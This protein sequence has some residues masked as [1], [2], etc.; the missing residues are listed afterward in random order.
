[1]SELTSKQQ[2][3]VEEYLIDLNATKAAMRAGY[4]K[5]TARQVGA[6]NLSKPV[7]ATAIQKAMEERSERTGIDQDWVLNN[8]RSITERCMQVEP[9]TDSKGDPVFVENAEGGI[10][11]AFTFN[12]TG[13]NR[14]LEL[15]GKHLG[16][17]VERKEHTGKD[18]GPIQYENIDV[19]EARKRVAEQF[20]EY[21]GD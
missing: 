9:V 2:R 18:G 1:M 13:A 20:A 6:E 21:T 14:A 15:I 12:S 5:R 7:I 3:F 8:L 17:F 16:M 4:S 10:V 19:E 11:P